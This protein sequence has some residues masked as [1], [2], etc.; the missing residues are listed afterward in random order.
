MLMEEIKKM[1]RNHPGKVITG[2][3]TCKFCGQR[4]ACK[5]LEDWTKEQK[6][7]QLRKTASARKQNGTRQKKNR[8]KG[9]ETVSQCSS[10]KITVSY[11]VMKRC[12]NCLIKSLTKSAREE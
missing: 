11:H 9:R 10:G 6:M 3:G 2:Y 1:E 12:W 7:K 5:M 8:K 4:A